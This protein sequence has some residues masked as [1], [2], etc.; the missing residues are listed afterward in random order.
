MRA[1]AY[2]S[3]EQHASGMTKPRAADAARVTPQ[4]CLRHVTPQA[5]LRH[6]THEGHEGETFVRSVS[7]NVDPDQ[8]TVRMR[9]A[10]AD[11]QQAI[12]PCRGGAG[13]LEA[14]YGS[15]TGALPRHIPA[16]QPACVAA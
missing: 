4:A 7:D 1:A 8:H 2:A 9:F 12:R 14:G 15:E 16:A 10:E 6:V 13:G 3:C 5:C 11:R